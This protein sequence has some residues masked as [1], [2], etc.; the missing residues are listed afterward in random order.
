MSW[1]RGGFCI[2]CGEC[3]AG[4]P[5]SNPT[6]PHWSNNMRRTPPVAGM[7]PLF[8]WRQ[9]ADAPPGQTWGYCIGHTGA[10]PAGQEDPYY[11]SGCNVWPQDPAQIA[12]YP[13]CTYTFTWVPD[14]N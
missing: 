6:D 2:H 9:K 1:Q 8:E 4:S 12:N 11:L 13:S 14:G 10:V 3:C 5:V 7:C